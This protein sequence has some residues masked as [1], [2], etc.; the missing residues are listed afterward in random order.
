[1]QEFHEHHVAEDA[2][3]RATQAGEL[4]KLR[5]A[6]NHLW[7]NVA[8]YLAISVI[9]FYLAIVGHSQTLRADALNNLSGIISAALLL[10]G[11]FIARDVDDDDLLG[12]P[13]PEDSPQAGQ[14]LQ[15]T[16]FHYETVF[17]LITGI[18][19]V[20]ISFSV[21][22]SGLKSLIHPEE[23][24]IPRP[25]R[26]TGD[27]ATDYLSWGRGCAGHHAGRLVVEPSRRAPVEQRRVECG[28][29]G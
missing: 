28:R 13:L 21:L 6:Q 4:Q 7:L 24:E 20:G 11:I 9:E 15:L 3:W 17:T 14:R 23:Q 26:G 5:R 29:T 19:M 1:M 16:R 27:S 10:V 22:F 25:T 18:V 12:Q 2:Q 8:A